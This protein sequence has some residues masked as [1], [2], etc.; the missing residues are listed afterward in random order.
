LQ[1]YTQNRKTAS[2]STFGT[3]SAFGSTQPTNTGIF[4][5]Q[6]N[7]P[8]STSAFGGG[9]TNT[10]GFGAFGQ[11]SN[12][13]STTQPGAGIFGSGS[14]FG[15]Q[16]QQQ[17]QQQQ[18]SG[19]NAFGQQQQQPQQQQQQQQQ[20]QHQQP[21]QGG[22]I[23]GGGSAFGNTANKPGFGST[24]A[25]GTSTWSLFLDRHQLLIAYC[26]APTTGTNIFGGGSSGTSAFG[27]TQQPQQQQPSIFG[28]AQPTSQNAFGALGM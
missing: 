1:D 26:I 21:Q 16:P 8:S 17:Q 2:S 19:F 18:P 7:Q 27:Q 22:G 23:F 10:G 25:F 12:Q 28:N 11:Q 13:P 5:A 20:Q 14:T 6:S 15:Q 4:G 3:T 24:G 9:T